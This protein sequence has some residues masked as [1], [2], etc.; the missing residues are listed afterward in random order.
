MKYKQWF[1]N[2][3]YECHGNKIK[4]YAIEVK[5][6]DKLKLTPYNTRNI[7]DQLGRT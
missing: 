1:K 7:S 5:F 3:Q 6:T 2:A 4:C